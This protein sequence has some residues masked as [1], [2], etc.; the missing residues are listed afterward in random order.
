MTSE[1]MENSGII[2][3]KH[4]FPAGNGGLPGTQGG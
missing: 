2:G 1:A 3:M 4:Y